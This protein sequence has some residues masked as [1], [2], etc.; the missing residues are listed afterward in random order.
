MKSMLLPDE[1][2]EN[3]IE[4]YTYQ[5]ITNTQK[6]YWIVLTSI[7]LSII[8]LPFIY[9]DI[10]IPNKGIIRPMIEKIEIKSTISE[11]VDSIYIKEGEKI[12][13]GDTILCF[14]TKKI[15]YKGY[16]E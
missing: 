6:I 1:W 3:S 2:I 4:S 5:H 9:I 7:G 12:Q 11:K 14:C 13:K 16:F 8:S 10:S 15:D